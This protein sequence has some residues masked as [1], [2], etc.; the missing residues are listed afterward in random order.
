V[1]KSYNFL[2]WYQKWNSKSKLVLSG[3]NLGRH[4]VESEMGVVGR[5]AALSAQWGWRASCQPR[6][7][8][9]ISKLYVVVVVFPPYHHFRGWDLSQFSSG[10][11]TISFT[12]SYNVMCDVP[13]NI[14]PKHYWSIL[15]FSYFWKMYIL[16]NKF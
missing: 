16:L 7:Q 9:V 2:K 1:K 4:F 6:L 5:E 15:K 3:V 12:L 8:S 11:C 10:V 13:T 14:Y